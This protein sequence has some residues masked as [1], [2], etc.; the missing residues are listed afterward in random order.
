MNTLKKWETT[1]EGK[2]AFFDNGTEIGAVEIARGTIERIAHARIN[3]QELTI[4]K[5]G[6]WKTNTEIIDKNG[7]IIAKVYPEKWY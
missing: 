4:K 2:Y 1:G 6:T 3:N 5:T 7:A